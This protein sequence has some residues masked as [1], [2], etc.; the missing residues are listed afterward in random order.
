M[1]KIATFWSWFSDHLEPLTMLADLEENEREQLLE[2]LQ[3]QLSLYCDGLTY[4]IG[5]PTP[6]GR[7]ITIS[8]E[9]DGDLF[10]TLLALTD[11]APDFDWWEVIPFKQPRG[12][13]LKVLFDR[14]TFETK[15]M[16]FQQLENEIEPDIIGLRVA[17][18]HGDND[19]EDQL[20]GVYSTIEALIGEFDCSTLL[21]YLEI[22]PIPKEPT[23]EGYQPLDELPSFV[24]WFKAQRDK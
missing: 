1:D 16:Y 21:G 19:N 24:E 9:G 14:Y 8:A 6:N 3:E 11:N 13:G 5:N 12:K 7:T 4:E 23:K 17:L 18:P 2:A 22:C 20:I 15:K 10:E